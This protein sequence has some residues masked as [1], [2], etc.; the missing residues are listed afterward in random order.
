MILAINLTDDAGKGQVSL[1]WTGAE[2]EADLICVRRGLTPAASTVKLEDDNPARE[3]IVMESL[4]GS[5][6]VVRDL[7][8]EGWRVAIEAVPVRWEASG[9]PLDT[10]GVADVHDVAV[11]ES[12][13]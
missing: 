12:H 10:G 9:E 8:L 13:C 3:W 6:D 2:R 1:L 5:A 7:E 11:V 4:V